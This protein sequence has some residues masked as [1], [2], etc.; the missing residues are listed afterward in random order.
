MPKALITTV[1]FGDQNRLPIEQL[2]AAGIEY[3]IN[4]IGR[5]LKEEELAEMVTNFDVL[6][7]GT[8]PITDNVMSRAS[9]LKLISRVGIGLDSVDLLAADQRGIQV[10]YTPDAPAPAVAEFTIGLMLSLLRSVHVNNAQMHRGEWHRHFGRRIPEITIGII[11]AGRIGGRVLR[12]LAG[13][14]NPRILAN[15]THLNLKVAPELK[16]ELVSK[17]EIYQKADLISLHVPLTA[18]TKNMI[19]REH[20]LQ[21]KA[22]AIIVNTSR[23]GIINEHDLAE[24]LNAGHLSGAAIDVFEQEPYTG[25]LA[26]ID[27]CLLTSHI[28]S[29]SVD[30]R[31]RMEIE[32][33]EEAVRFLTGKPLQGLVPQEEYEVQK[34]GL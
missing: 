23:G 8:E 30:C 3:L 11:G 19:T 34:Q 33:T 16:I 14:G 32:A 27:R 26:R 18:Q 17:E 5:K 31:T 4:P 20:L 21:M 12:H 2:E 22:D 25:A 9:R 7:A 13:F 6:I 15:D 1:P 28:G 29:M 10:S 24:V